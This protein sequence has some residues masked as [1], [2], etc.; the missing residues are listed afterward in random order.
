MSA[1]AARRMVTPG[2]AVRSRRRRS[3]WLV[4]LAASL[5]VVLGGVASSAAT[6]VPRHTGTDQLA[7]AQPP[8]PLPPNPGCEPNSA[9]PA[10]HLPSTSSA[11]SIPATPL[12]PITAL[13]ALP[14]CFPGSLD[15]GC[16]PATSS[17]CQ[18][19]NC[20][21]QPSTLVPSTPPSA[22]VPDGAGGDAAECGLTDLTGC[23]V[24]AASTLL[25]AVVAA[26]MNP[27]LDL[28]GKTLLTTPEPD[29][30][31][32]LGAVWVGSWHIL[33]TAYVILVLLAGLIIMGY[34]TLQARYT[35]KELAPRLVVGFL[36]GTFSLFLMTKGVQV[37]NALS[38]AVLGEGVDQAQMTRSLISMVQG[39][40]HGG[41]IFLGI[42]GLVLVA[43]LLVLLVV[44]VV[45]V[46]VTILLVAAAPIVL[47]FH[48]LPHTEGIAYPWWKASGGV[49]AIQVGQSLTLVVTVRVFF[50]PGG[51]TIFGPS[52]S[53]L[54]NLLL[55][56]AL[57]YVLIK[58]PFWFLAPLRSGRPSL[59]GRIA[60]GVIAYKT[61]GLLSSAAAARGTSRVR[62]DGP[63]APPDPPATR[64][65]QF[66]LPM[67]LRRSTS[68]RQNPRRG[69][70][71]LPRAGALDGTPGP[72]QLSLFTTRTGDSTIRTNPRALPLKDLPNALPADQLGLPITVRREP[73]RPSRRTLADDLAAPPPTV[74]P[75]RQP[76]LLTPDGRINRN[77]R[78]PTKLPNALIAPSAG[79]LPIHLPPQTP[80]P[81]RRSLADE[82]ADPT[83]TTSAPQT[84]PGLITPSG[85]INRA[86]R[87]HRRPA[88]DA[89]SGNRPLASGQ[90]P[91]PLG[92]RRQPKPVPPASPTPVR[93]PG[94]KQLPL[95]LDL[96]PRRPRK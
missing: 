57:M 15:P 89:F 91:L 67:K 7:P 59:L 51:F 4:A 32:G 55:C 71:E 21:P 62:P 25:A 95:P 14:S 73:D 72:G 53:S 77:A 5:T 29:Q 90:Y 13:P 58:I 39:S 27:L 19:P 3:F 80:R 45:R 40:L 81:A 43:M 12:P 47:M 76:G 74:R 66:M 30:L 2:H 82:L 10:C 78:P 63:S 18:G 75:A 48:A 8:L 28:L 34:Q 31:P 23:M 42:L 69:W 93:K 35:V 83:R 87:A 6:A 26:G 88:P 70:D 54:M 16:A 94:G 44:F 92:L 52:L 56:I 24:V 96:P 61:M 86:A 1:H 38:A 9:E 20:I 49:L 85:Q 41:G 37:A 64:S 46:M 65:G 17:P 22:S 36:A 33:L 50:A 11:P 60:R 79:M 68:S 84:G